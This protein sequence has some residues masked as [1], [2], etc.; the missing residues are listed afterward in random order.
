MTFN[1]IR[2]KDYALTPGESYEMSPFLVRKGVFVRCK[3]RGSLEG[4]TLLRGTT[5]ACD[6]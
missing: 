6:R 5:H 4:S 2:A 3:S 1:M